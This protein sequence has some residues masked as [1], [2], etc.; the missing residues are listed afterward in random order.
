MSKRMFDHEMECPKCEKLN[1]FGTRFCF[2]CGVSLAK[3]QEGVEQLYKFVDL[4]NKERERIILKA[5]VD[6]GIKQNNIGP[7][8]AESPKSYIFTIRQ[9][10]WRLFATQINNTTWAWRESSSKVR[11]SCEQLVKQGLLARAYNPQYCCY[12]YFL[13]LAE[14]EL[15]THF[16]W[17][18]IKKFY[19]GHEDCIHNKD[20]NCLQEY[21]TLDE[22]LDCFEEKEVSVS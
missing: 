12:F 5:I 20:C 18:K 4:P 17:I 1:E 15:E 9:I 16:H 11:Y 22:N 8:I 14:K 10:R 2:E 21:K 19:C 13:P 3:T 6:D 7:T